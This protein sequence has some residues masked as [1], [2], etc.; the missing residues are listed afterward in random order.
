MFLFINL[1]ITLMG[2]KH[3]SIGAIITSIV[4][5][6]CVIAT[7]CSKNDNGV[8]TSNLKAGTAGTCPSSLTCPGSGFACGCYTVSGLGANKSAI[9]SGNQYFMASAMMETEMMA[10]NYTL[11]DGKTGDA[12]NAGRTKLNYYEARMAGVGQ[13]STSALWNAC[14][15][16]SKDVSIWNSCKSYWGS[17]YWSVHTDGA[18]GAK[19]CSSPSTN[20]KNFK[21]MTD[22][23]N[24]QIGNHQTDNVRFW[25]FYNNVI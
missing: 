15:S 8:A 9:G 23:T 19:N 6:A 25:V 14:L 13:G 20:A 18:S 10:V 1:I 22:W 7:S 12:F 4:F 5:I 24:N 17:C 3:L 11:G 16:A 21:I 2:R